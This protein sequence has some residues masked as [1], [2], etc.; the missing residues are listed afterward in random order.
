MLTL[1]ITG[2][3]DVSSSHSTDP[4]SNGGETSDNDADSVTTVSTLRDTNASV[5][6]SAVQA[7]GYIAA[8]APSRSD[9]S[10]SVRLAARTVS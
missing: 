8:A 3:Y 9:E 1:L 2:Q 4:A 10:A 7:S 5:M 6:Q